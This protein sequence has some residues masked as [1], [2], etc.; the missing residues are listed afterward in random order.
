MNRF[1]FMESTGKKPELLPTTVPKNGL[2][3]VGQRWINKINGNTISIQERTHR[4]AWVVRETSKG[5][6][7]SYDEGLKE[8]RENFILEFYR[9][10]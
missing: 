7:R 6:L 10:T 8:L 3:D 5:A 9:L 4:G 2:V 1:N